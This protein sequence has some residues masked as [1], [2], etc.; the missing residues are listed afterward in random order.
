MCIR[1]SIYIAVREKVR[2]CIIRH[3]LLTLTLAPLVT[4]LRIR[5]IADSGEIPSGALALRFMPLGILKVISNYER[6]VIRGYSFYMAFTRH[7]KSVITKL[8]FPEERIILR[9][10]S[11]D[12]SKIPIHDEAP[13]FTFGYFGVLERWQGLDFLLRSF[14]RAIKKDARLKLFVIGEGSMKGYLQ[15][16]ARELGIHDK[17]TFCGSVP[18]EIMLKEYFKLFRVAIIPRPPMK[19]PVNP[20]KLVEALASGKPVVATRVPGIADLVN[21]GEGVTFVAP[22][23]EEDLARAILNLASN[24]EWLNSLSKKALRTATRFDIELQLDLLI[25]KLER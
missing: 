15:T 23:D 11:I 22:N 19:V 12:L 21:E 17:V 4:L 5:S 7:Q 24:D 10:I 14:S 2:Y 20:I 3:T 9:Q 18:R 16:L 8:G 6:G 1:D 25:K 13:R